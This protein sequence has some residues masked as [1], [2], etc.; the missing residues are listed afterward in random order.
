MFTTLLLLVITGCDEVSQKTCDGLS[1]QDGEEITLQL[2][3]L[4]YSQVDTGGGLGDTYQLIISDDATWAE[5]VTAW[6]DDGGLTPDFS[7]ETV[8]VH[9]WVFGGCGEAYHYGAWRWDDVLRVRAEYE[10]EGAVCDAY[11]PQVD[12]LVV[13]HGGAS[14]LGWCE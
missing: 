13:P 14:D 12:L 8:F 10:S 2:V 6:G 4:G 7:V 11:M 5:Q 1:P 3:E 9:A